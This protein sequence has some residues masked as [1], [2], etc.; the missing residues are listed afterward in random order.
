M[1]SLSDWLAGLADGVAE[2]VGDSTGGGTGSGVLVIMFDGTADGDGVGVGAGARAAT[3]AEGVGVGVAAL[4]AGMAMESARAVATRPAPAPRANLCGRHRV[5][6]SIN[7][8]QVVIMG[9][10]PR[11]WVGVVGLGDWHPS[12]TN[13][14][15]FS[16]PQTTRKLTRGM[17]KWPV[18]PLLLELKAPQCHVHGVI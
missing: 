7:L 3:D 17:L 8:D 5:D 10:A 11:R 2:V 15:P 6:P 1:R 13:E 4:A 16:G 14:C 9:R 12:G 18:L